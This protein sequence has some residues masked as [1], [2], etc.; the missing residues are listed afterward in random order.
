MD[1]I[2]NL[3]SVSSVYFFIFALIYAG[4]ALAFRNGFLAEFFLDLMRILDIPFAFV[5]LLY[6]F[7]TLAIQISTSKEENSGLSPWILVIL[8][9]CLLLFGAV[10]FVNFAFPSQF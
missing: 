3:H 1:K 5:G 9:V 8:V 7:S 6:G 10:V 4:M 2:K